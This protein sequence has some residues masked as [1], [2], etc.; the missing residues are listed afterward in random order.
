MAELFDFDIL[1]YFL[2]LSTIISFLWYFTSKI[3]FSGKRVL[4]FTPINVETKRDRPLPCKVPSFSFDNILEKSKTWQIKIPDKVNLKGNEDLLS[5]T[6][7]V[8]VKPTLRG[9]DSTTYL[10]KPHKTVKQMYNIRRI[11]IKAEI[12]LVFLTSIISKKWSAIRH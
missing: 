9:F 11:T 6:G 8:I 1:W 2:L 3:I 4:P 5:I 10:L 12:I 7:H